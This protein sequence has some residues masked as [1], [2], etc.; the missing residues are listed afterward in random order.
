MNRT[1]EN[2][3]RNKQCWGDG[4]V[5]GRFDRGETACAARVRLW[6]HRT[7]CEAAGVMLAQDCGEDFERDNLCSCSRPVDLLSEPDMC[8]MHGHLHSVEDPFTL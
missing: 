8:R 1:A 3:F 5:Q 6:L 7:H 2:T 4:S